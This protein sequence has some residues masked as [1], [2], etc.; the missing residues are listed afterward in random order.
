MNHTVKIPVTRDV[1]DLIECS[2]PN[3][4]DP[5]CSE[6]CIYGKCHPDAKLTCLY[7][8]VTGTLSLYCGECGELIIPIQVA[9]HA[10]AGVLGNVT[11]TH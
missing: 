8:R 2:N 11:V 10:A 3:C 5:D 9:Q 1:L 7:D 6:V 4:K